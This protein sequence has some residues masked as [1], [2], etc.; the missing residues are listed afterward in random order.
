M[1]K[2]I[3]W[4]KLGLVLILL[5]SLG[6]F[7]PTAVYAASPPT[8]TS[9]NPSSGEPGEA[10]ELSIIG[11][12]F[13]EEVEIFFSGI[14]IS[15][16]SV[17]FP[18]EN[19]IIISI[20]I[21]EDAPLGPR[22]MMVFNPDD[23]SYTL[24]GGFTIVEAPLLAP[25]IT[26]LSLNIVEQGETV[27]I[28]I[29]GENFTEPIELD[30]GG[31]G[32]T[33]IDGGIISSGEIVVRIAIAE[34]APLGPMD[35][36]IVNSDGQTYTFEGGL[37]IVDT[38]FPQIITGLTATDTH[39]GKIDLSWNPSA[40]NDFYAYRIFVSKSD[41][42]D[43]SG[44]EHIGKITDIGD[45]SYQVSGL[46]NGVAYYFAV[47]VIDVNG[48]ED[49][50]VSDVS[51]T[52]TLSVVPDSTP[53][54]AT[55]VGTLSGGQHLIDMAAE[56]ITFSVIWTGDPAEAVYVVVNSLDYPLSYIGTG[57]L[58]ASAF[59]YGEL[60]LTADDTFEYLFRSGGIIVMGGSGQLAV[61]SLWDSICNF[62][63]AVWNWLLDLGEDVWDTIGF[64]GVALLA[65]AAIIAAA[66]GIT[67]APLLIILGA[68]AALA[69]GIWKGRHR[70]WKF[71]KWLWE[72]LKV[73]G[74][75]W[76]N[77]VLKPFGK[78]VGK[79]AKEAGKW[80]GKKAKEAGKWVGK[81]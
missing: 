79:K 74:K 72:K 33:F 45:T 57:Q 22:D 53:P 59:T 49:I 24:E 63:V 47:T 62:F 3:S 13:A 37:T 70:W 67:I 71:L 60:N 4:L 10:I 17:T 9:V 43:V 75:W 58:W 29:F 44:I 42:T 19:E 21:A 30:F 80:V 40:V 1:L 16:T 39:D 5:T 81:K 56:A 76:W 28:N 52:P 64:L 8:I 36:L 27:D 38:T 66:L 78:W 68:L 12:N 15:I 32:I 26:G 25:I 11:E 7:T 31:A 34:D 48:N 46:E 6:L 14:G 18:S 50:V 61:T 69:W 35:V 55:V 73:A 2:N 51:A 23:Q 41:I 77:K 54:P 20:V 65:I